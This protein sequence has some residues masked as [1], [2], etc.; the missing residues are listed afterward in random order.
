MSKYQA[1][2]SSW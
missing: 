2:N 1:T